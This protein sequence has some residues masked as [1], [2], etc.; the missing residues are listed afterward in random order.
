MFPISRPAVSQHLKVLKD[1][2]LVRVVGPGRLSAYELAPAP[3][4]EIEHWV[5]TLAL[6]WAQG[7][8]SPVNRNT[9]STA[10]E[11]LRTLPVT[12]VEINSPDLERS[13][14]FFTDVF[15]WQ[16]RA[17]ADPG[18]L[19]A[20]AGDGPGVDTGLMGSADGAPRSIP[21]IRV[22]SLEGLRTL[23]ENHGGT[24]VV[25]PFAIAGVGRACYILDPAG[26]LVGLHEYDA[27][28]R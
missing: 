16:L 8:L 2:G 1:A 20:P 24:V 5:S 14:A 3:L 15:D 22:P 26:V 7:P 28:S 25:E 13:A 4:L 9:R 17:F 21:V 6:A 10:L 18:Y 23:V 27:D 19:V 11:A 12:Y